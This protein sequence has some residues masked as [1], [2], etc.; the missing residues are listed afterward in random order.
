MTPEQVEEMGEYAHIYM[1]KDGRI[2]MAGLNEQNIQVR[3][4]FYSYSTVAD[5]AVLCR[6]YV[7][8]CQGRIEEQVVF[9][10]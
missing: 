8:V 10:D 2:S 5:A 6:E 1:T 7:Q 9:V 3:P 4:H